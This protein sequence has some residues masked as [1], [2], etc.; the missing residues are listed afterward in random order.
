MPILVL[1]HVPCMCFWCFL[2]CLSLSVGV[3]FV[4]IA[5][6]ARSLVHAGRSYIDAADW[7]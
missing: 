1:P 5:A 7:V 3:S 6:V 4:D 2:Y